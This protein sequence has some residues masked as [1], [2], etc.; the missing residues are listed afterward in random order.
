MAKQ[1]RAK[2]NTHPSLCANIRPEPW[3]GGVKWV[4]EGSSHPVASMATLR[5][6]F[7]CRRLRSTARAF[8]SFGGNVHNKG[9]VYHHFDHGG[10][11]LL[12]IGWDYHTQVQGG[13]IHPPVPERLLV[14]QSQ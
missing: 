6:R 3:S 2:K 12:N 14:F 11:L 1:Q 5:A 9:S 10:V 8:V 13:I 4:R 7:S